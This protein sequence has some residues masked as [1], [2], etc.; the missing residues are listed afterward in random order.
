MYKLTKYLK[1]PLRRKIML[2]EVLLW[3]FLAKVMLLIF[4]FKKLSEILGDSQ[5][6]SFYTAN[7]QETIIVNDFIKN[8]NAVLKNLPW[9]C[10]CLTQ[11]IAGKFMLKV[12]KIKTTI[13]LG[14]GKNEEGDFS[15]HAWLKI[16]DFFITG[17]SNVQKYKTL[18]K[19][20]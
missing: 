6:S 8:L 20:T 7:S 2:I 10:R 13:Y 11:A 9:Q 4:S 12:R 3:L 16:G 15:A 5:N 14:M 1:L 19:L 17:N 18:V